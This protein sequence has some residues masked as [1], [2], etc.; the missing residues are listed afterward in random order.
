MAQR[1]RFGVP[2]AVLALFI[3]VAVLAPWISPYDPLKFDI[4]NRLTGPSGQHWLGA[5]EFGRDILSRLIH[6]TRAA[7]AIS[8]GSAT[9]AMVVGSVLGLLGGYFSGLVE[10]VTVRL[11]DV[12]LSFPPIVLAIL[13]VTLL[14]PGVATLIFV[15]GFLYVPS[16]AR[17]TYGQVLSVKTAEYVQAA[18]ALGSGHLRIIVRT[19]LPNVQAPLIVQFSLTVAAATLIEAGLS[20]LGLGVVPPTPTWGLMIRSA[21]DYMDRDPNYLLWPSL[22]IVLVILAINSLGDALR[23]RLDPRLRGLA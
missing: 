12:I 21:R 14:G 17:L 11:A 10:L 20:F 6:G 4:P 13:V 9:L 15:I 2:M 3:L 1:L 5:D 8:I 18:R 23:D 16:F 22:V 7:I 19:I